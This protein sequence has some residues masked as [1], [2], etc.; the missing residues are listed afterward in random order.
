[1]KHATQVALTRRF[2]AH[3][4]RQSTDLA[5]HV[6]FNTPH[7]YVDNDHFA[8]E[9]S[10]LFARRPLLVGLSCQ[11]PTP[12]DFLTEDFA[13]IPVL[14]TRAQDGRARAFMNVCRHRGSRLES[15]TMGCGRQKFTCPYHAWSY[16]LEGRLVG[17]P[18]ASTFGDIERDEY[19]L[20]PLPV[21]ECNGLIWV[22]HTPRGEA[23]NAEALLGADLSA[24]IAAYDLSTWHHYETRRLDYAMNWKG[25]IDTFLEVYHFGKL[26]RASIASIFYDNLVLFDAFGRNLRMSAAR[27]SIELVRERETQSEDLLVH[28]AH[29]YVLF[30]NAVLVRQGE[31]IETWRVYPGATP[32]SCR[33]VVS[34]FIPQPAQS[35]SARRHWDNNM[36]LLLNTVLDEDFPVGANIQKN[37]HSGAQTQVTYGRNEPALAH[38]H[39]ML[40]EV[41]A[42]SAA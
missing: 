42:V 27:R 3:I 35:D 13:G 23:F 37:F 24:E 33:M 34:M 11:I 36:N 7:V 12:G 25:V 31:Q 5:A 30:P 2:L 39:Q 22:R 32:D 41:L 18:D 10:L 6:S 28:M 14:V 8:R 16:N 17:V 15:E 1:M 38:Y 40:R 20:V 21:D 29:V 4:D 19:G 9:K 26:H